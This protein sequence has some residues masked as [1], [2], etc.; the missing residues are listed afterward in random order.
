MC[1]YF[2]QNET[3]LVSKSHF[4]LLQVNPELDKIQDDVD[5]YL[6]EDSY[7]KYRFVQFRAKVLA[8]SEA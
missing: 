1:S 4:Y 5:K 7:D 8:D 6:G 3:V 2:Q